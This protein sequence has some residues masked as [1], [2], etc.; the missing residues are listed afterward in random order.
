MRK[1]RG[2]DRL[3]TEEELHQVLAVLHEFAPSGW[4]VPEDDS[5]DPQA[6]S[7]WADAV[8]DDSADAESLADLLAKKP[9]LRN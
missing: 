2:F 9:E 1:S 7:L 3:S 6:T 8:L 4:M 5:A